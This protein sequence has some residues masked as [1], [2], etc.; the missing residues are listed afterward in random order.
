MLL[1]G[2]KINDILSALTEGLQH[3]DCRWPD[4]SNSDFMSV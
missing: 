1:K 4:S 2:T 3:A